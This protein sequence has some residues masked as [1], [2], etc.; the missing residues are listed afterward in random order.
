MKVDPVDLHELKNLN[1]HRHLYP[2]WM[3][4]TS[5]YCWMR[6][7]QVMGVDGIER[8]DDPHLRSLRIHPRDY[9]P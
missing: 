6:W 7:D 1:I 5:L 9:D 3:M 8:G 4:L 2:P